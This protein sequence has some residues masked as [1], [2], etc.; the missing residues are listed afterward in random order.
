MASL[1][2]M[3][4]LV[5][6]TLLCRFG[7]AHWPSFRS[8]ILCKTSM[9]RVRHDTA[10]GCMCVCACACASACVCVLFVLCVCAHVCACKGGTS[11]NKTRKQANQQASKAAA[12]FKGSKTTKHGGC[13]SKSKRKD[14]STSNRNC[15]GRTKCPINSGM[16]KHMRTHKNE[17]KGK[18]NGQG[19]CISKRNSKF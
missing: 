2:S 6:R 3:Y 19:Q 15:T 5:I 10:N 16:H 12:K 1:Q 9:V 8:A 18:R 13:T 11:Q 4:I 17:G 14:N 7:L